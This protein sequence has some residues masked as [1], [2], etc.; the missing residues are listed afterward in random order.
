MNRSA[1]NRSSLLQFENLFYYYGKREESIL[2]FRKKKAI[3]KCTNIIFYSFENRETWCT[4]VTPRIA[5]LPHSR[6]RSNFERTSVCPR[7]ACSVPMFYNEP[8]KLYE[9]SD[10]TSV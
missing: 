3:G 6:I 9:C 4:I 8:M 10:V 7:G 1:F 2:S 5:L